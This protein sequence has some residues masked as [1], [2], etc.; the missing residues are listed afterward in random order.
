[1][2]SCDLYLL[3]ATFDTFSHFKSIL[4]RDLGYVGEKMGAI[5]YPPYNYSRLGLMSTLLKNRKLPDLNWLGYL[6]SFVAGV[7]SI[8]VS[9]VF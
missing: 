3:Q 9:K 2:I 4:I 8:I 1:M 6:L 7:I 5:R